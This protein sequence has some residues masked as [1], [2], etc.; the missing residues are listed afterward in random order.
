M[1]IDA[2]A[3]SPVV[4]VAKRIPSYMLPKKKSSPQ[5]RTHR[6]TP[7]TQIVKSKP[8]KGNAGAAS[9]EFRTSMV[10]DAQ[11]ESKIEVTQS[12]V[13][14][15]DILAVG[16]MLMICSLQMRS[17]MMQLRTSS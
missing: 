1:S 13:S 12:N 4:P 3:E 16:M 10:D 7:E 11:V 9:K 2:H 6:S 8:V 5:K 17:R 15:L 14:I